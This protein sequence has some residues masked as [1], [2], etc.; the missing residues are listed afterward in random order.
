MLLSAKAARLLPHLFHTRRLSPRF[1]VASHVSVASSSSEILVAN[2]TN[3]PRAS[4]PWLSFM[5]ELEWICIA[6]CHCSLHSLEGAHHDVPHLLLLLSLA[7]DPDFAEPVR[8]PLQAHLNRSVL[9]VLPQTQLQHPLKG[10]QHLLLHIHVAAPVHHLV[11]G[12]RQLGN[13]LLELTPRLFPTF[14]TKKE[15]RVPAAGAWPSVDRAVNCE[16]TAGVWYIN[17]IRCMEKPRPHHCRSSGQIGLGT[18]LGS[19]HFPRMCRSAVYASTPYVFWS[20]AACLSEGP[21]FASSHRT[22]ASMF[23]PRPASTALSTTL[24]MPCGRAIGSLARCPGPLADGTLAYGIICRSNR[25]NVSLLTTE[26]NTNA[27]L[28]TM[29]ALMMPASSTGHRATRRRA[30]ASISSEVGVRSSLEH[31]SAKELIFSATSS[32]IACGSHATVCEPSAL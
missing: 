23:C 7:P 9:H 3:L 6:L 13:T 20:S 32:W 17:V 15:A 12:P 10:L 27:R 26:S 29:L 4:L 21:S 14:R 2:T 5:G 19:M 28:A 18:S 8:F 31:V 30:A 11:P 16:P 1:G 22:G 24:P 25:P